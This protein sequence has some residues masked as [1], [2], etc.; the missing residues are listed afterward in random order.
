M[1]LLDFNGLKIVTQLPLCLC[2]NCT[3]ST[4]LMLVEFCTTWNL[5]IPHQQ[6]PE[7][8]IIDGFSW[9]FSFGFILYF[10]LYFRV[11]RKTN[12][13]LR[14]RCVRLRGGSTGAAGALIKGA[15]KDSRVKVPRR[16]EAPAVSRVCISQPVA[17]PRWSWPYG[18]PW[19]RVMLSPPITPKL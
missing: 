14:C 3:D 2:F 18:R 11:R 9:F 8:S 5:L 10:F 1:S 17:L 6:T 15:K 16:D 13:T 12:Q 7:Y 19:H 4:T